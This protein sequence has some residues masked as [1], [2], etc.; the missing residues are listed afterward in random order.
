[1]SYKYNEIID[2]LR[3][4]IL[5]PA[6]AAKAKGA[7]EEL[8][9]MHELDQSEIVRLRRMVEMKEENEKA[10]CQDVSF[11]SCNTCLKKGVCPHT[12]R[13]GQLCRINCFAYLGEDGLKEDGLKEDEKWKDLGE[14]NRSPYREETAAERRARYKRREFTPDEEEDLMTT[15]MLSEV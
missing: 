9:Y 14:G 12:P 11:R 7:I 5:T 4:Q 10:Y 8:L 3:R 1:M 2:D 6:L 15:L 13:P